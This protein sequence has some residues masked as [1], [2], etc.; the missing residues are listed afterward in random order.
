[1]EK[2]FR[3]D[4]IDLDFY[5]LLIMYRIDQLLQ[6][7]KLTM[8]NLY[9]NT[10]LS[11]IFR[12]KKIF[13]RFLIATIISMLFFGGINFVGYAQAL[14]ST[15]I[16]PMEPT[17]LYKR[18]ESDQ[19]KKL[20]PKKPYPTQGRGMLVAYAGEAYANLEFWNNQTLLE[21]LVTVGRSDK[22]T[23]YFFPCSAVK[24]GR[25]TVGWSTR[26]EGSNKCQNNVIAYL[27]GYGKYKTNLH[28]SVKNY[29]YSIKNK[30]LE[31]GRDHLNGKVEI[32]PIQDG[33]LILVDIAIRRD[34]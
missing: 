2:Y 28:Q 18:N 12:C 27:P 14:P 21:P 33:T 16:R 25:I 34:S 17:I 10:V 24:Q 19:G 13:Q 11:F 1:L 4:E 5:I 20:S 6:K 22:T 15:R 7:C 9:F 31:D 3:S 32:S 23:S 29:S 8:I 30:Q 26:K